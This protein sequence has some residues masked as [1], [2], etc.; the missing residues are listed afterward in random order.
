MSLT[1]RK[2]SKQVERRTLGFLKC[3][4]I[5][6]EIWEHP[7]CCNNENSFF[8]FSLSKNRSQ[9]SDPR[10]RERMKKDAWFSKTPDYIVTVYVKG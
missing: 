10:G 1:S 7:T 5:E 2:A 9:C 4:L 6:Y 3:S 8:F